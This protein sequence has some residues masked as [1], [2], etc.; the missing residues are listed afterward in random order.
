M[1]RPPVRL[2]E[3]PI[4]NEGRG[5]RYIRRQRENIELDR[6]LIQIAIEADANIPTAPSTVAQATLPGDERRLRGIPAIGRGVA[7]A[8]NGSRPGDGLE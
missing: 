2:D 8:I 6:Q 3:L 5:L 4:S 1:T 7:G